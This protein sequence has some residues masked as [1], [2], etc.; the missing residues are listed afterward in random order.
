MAPFRTYD[1]PTEAAKRPAC[2]TCGATMRLVW[3]VPDKLQR[4][5][6][7]LECQACKHAIEI[8]ADRDDN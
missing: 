1:P 8:M 5:R 4:D 7:V 6:H 2:P 3:I